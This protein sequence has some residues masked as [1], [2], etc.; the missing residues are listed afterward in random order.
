M[1]HVR[2]SDNRLTYRQYERLSDI[3]EY[4]SGPRPEIE[5]AGAK[6]ELYTLYRDLY[7]EDVEFSRD[8]V[9]YIFDDNYIDH[10]TSWHR[11]FL[12]WMCM[13]SV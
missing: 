6:R 13:K 8:H 2:L 10:L 1:E 5:W 3:I 12:E 4:I 7:P 11:R 9:D